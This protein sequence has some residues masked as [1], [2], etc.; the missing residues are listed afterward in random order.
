M[1]VV[2]Q[3]RDFALMTAVREGRT[4]VVSLLL[5]AEANTDLQNRVKFMS[6]NVYKE[7]WFKRK[8]GSFYC[9]MKSK[10]VSRIGKI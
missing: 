8:C 5:D 2:T 10:W 9:V 1:S 4:E 7:V 6:V 3:I